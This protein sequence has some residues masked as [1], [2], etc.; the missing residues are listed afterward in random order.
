MHSDFELL[1]LIKLDWKFKIVIWKKY[2]EKKKSFSFEIFDT[3]LLALSR[4]ST[5]HFFAFFFDSVQFIFFLINGLHKAATY[6]PHIVSCDPPKLQSV[7]V[8]I[9]WDCLNL[10]YVFTLITF[11]VLSFW[12]KWTQ[13]RYTIFN[14]FDFSWEKLTYFYF[15]CEMCNLLKELLNICQYSAVDSGFFVENFAYSS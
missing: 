15:K 8:L 13:Q 12:A 5:L 6:P 4:E 2:F 11:T 10:W 9:C 7:K 14:I 1:L 3:Y